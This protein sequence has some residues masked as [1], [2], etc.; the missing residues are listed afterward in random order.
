VPADLAARIAACPPAYMVLGV[1]QTA[2]R[3]DADP[4]EVA[5]LHFAL[6][7]LLGLPG[8]VTRILALP[9][10]DKWQTMARAALRDDL[11]SV[12]AQ[13][14]GQVLAATGDAPAADRVAAWRDAAEAEVGRA[15]AT[16]A[17]ICADDDADLAR[18]SVALRVV[19]GLVET[20]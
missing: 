19:R 13:L 16:V 12:H 4:L 20:P 5:R 8:L 15:V 18:M 3:A 1:V 6:G 9:R 14:T 11:H 7:E 2:A 10:R 17:T